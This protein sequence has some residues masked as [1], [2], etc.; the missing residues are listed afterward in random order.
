MK[1]K[2]NRKTKFEFQNLMVITTI[3]IVLLC[4]S[5]K[6]ESNSLKNTE[7]DLITKI[8][9]VQ[10]QVIAQGNMTEEEEQALLSL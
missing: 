8:N 2:F 6:E 10:N 7:S 4:F 3:F 1:Y 9:A 5:C